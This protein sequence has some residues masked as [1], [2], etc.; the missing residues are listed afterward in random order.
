ML[1]QEFSKRSPLFTRHFRSQGYVAVRE[2]YQ[3]AKIF[4]LEIL[5]SRGLGGVEVAIHKLGE[6]PINGFTMFRTVGLALDG[7]FLPIGK[8]EFSVDQILELSDIARPGV[9]VHPVYGVGLQ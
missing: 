5:N 3:V 9:A 7:Y 4:L 2:R 8:Q 1:F 6:S